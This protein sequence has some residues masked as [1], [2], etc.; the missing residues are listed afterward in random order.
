[1]SSSA[2]IE[3]ALIP[4]TASSSTRSRPASSGGAASRN[5]SGPIDTPNRLSSTDSAEVTTSWQFWSSAFEPR[6]SA[7]SIRPG[8]APTS[9]P[10]CT[11][12]SLVMRVPERSR[13]STTIVNFASAAMI[14]LRAGNA[15]RNAGVPG[16]ISETITPAS[17]ILSR[18]AP[19]V[20]G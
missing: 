8:T 10:S 19:L 9:R 12:N 11:A 6:A 20:R 2:P 7:E 13:H 18:S 14:R 5:P 17:A 3:P 16:G 15:H 1:M 4:A